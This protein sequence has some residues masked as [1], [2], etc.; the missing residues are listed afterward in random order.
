MAWQCASHATQADDVTARRPWCSC[1][2]ARRSDVV[3]RAPSASRACW[4]SSTLVAKLGGGVVQ[5][6]TQARR[7]PSQ[8]RQVALRHGGR[9]GRLALHRRLRRGRVSHV[10]RYGKFNDM[11]QS[12]APARGPRCRFYASQAILNRDTELRSSSVSAVSWR[13]E[14]AVW[15]VPDVV[16]AVTWRMPSMWRATLV[17]SPASCEVVLRDLLDQL[18]QLA[19]HAANLDQCGTG[20]IGQPRP[21]TTPCVLRSMAC[22]ASWVSV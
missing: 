11:T 10:A 8:H 19:R 5:R 18:G 2:P 21:S 14:V 9:R 20:V 12:V 17:A 22:T 4:I 16:W 7:E 3:S 6:G 15:R 13:T 1:W